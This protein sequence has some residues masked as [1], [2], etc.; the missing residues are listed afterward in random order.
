MKSCGDHGSAPGAEWGG[1]TSAPA[2]GRILRAAAH[3]RCPEAL[4]EF[5]LAGRELT[6]ATKAQDGLGEGATPLDVEGA[7]A[8]VDYAI[9][10]QDRAIGRLEAALAESMEVVT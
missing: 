9:E 1:S 4:L 3:G 8:R 7:A 5:Y 10:R 6:A 2:T